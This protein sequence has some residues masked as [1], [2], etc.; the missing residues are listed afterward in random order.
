MFKKVYRNEYIV[1][2]FVALVLYI[3]GERHFP[4]LELKAYFMVPSGVMWFFF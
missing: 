3:T 2:V 1:K 4:F